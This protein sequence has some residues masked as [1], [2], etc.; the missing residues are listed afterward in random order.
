MP[1]FQ[2]R[3]LPDPIYK[4]LQELAAKERRSMAQ[5]AIVLLANC[6]GIELDDQTRRRNIIAN[7]RQKNHDLGLDD[8][9]IL[10]TIQE[11]RNR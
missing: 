6:L 11:D 5:Q 10:R 7:F 9:Q 2:V 1:S 8:D 3:D 4:K